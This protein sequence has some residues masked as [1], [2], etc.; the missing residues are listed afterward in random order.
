MIL[1]EYRRPDVALLEIKLPHLN[2]IA[3]AREISSR[4]ARSKPIF[5]TAHTDEGY[6]N[7]AFKA[8]ARGYVAGDSATTDLPRAIRIVSS[9]GFFLS[10]K[11]CE[12]LFDR[13]LKAGTISVYGK[14]LCCLSAAGYDDDEIAVALKAD[15]EKIRRDRLGLKPLFRGNTLPEALTQCVFAKE[16]ALE[17]S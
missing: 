3:V 16:C 2:G 15:V 6:V 13:D 7:E 12:Q 11:I 17:N 10:P 9:G 1:A 14:T 5:V 8:G 4:A